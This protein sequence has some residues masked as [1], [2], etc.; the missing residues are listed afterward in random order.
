MSKPLGRPTLDRVN[1]SVKVWVSLP[2]PVYNAMLLKSGEFVP[3]KALRKIVTEY[4]AEKPT[5]TQ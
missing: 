3:V 2:I 5:A 4:V 1:K